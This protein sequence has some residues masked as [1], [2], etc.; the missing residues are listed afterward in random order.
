MMKRYMIL[1]RPFVA[2]AAF[3]VLG[4]T[5]L[6]PGTTVRADS[7]EPDADRSEQVAPDDDTG[8]FW[9]TRALT[10]SMVRRWSLDI[11]ET[12][13]LSREQYEQLESRML[14]RWPAFFEENRAELQPLVNEYLELRM[15]VEPPTA[16]QVSSWAARAIPALDR[17]RGEIESAQQDTLE[18]LDA[19]QKRKFES[20]R[21]KLG[22]AL[23]MAEGVLKQWS[24]GSF[25]MKDVWD[26]PNGPTQ[27]VQGAPDQ[28]GSSAAARPE[29][30]VESIDSS[31][32]ARLAEELHE[33]ERYVAEFCDRYEL[34]RSQRNAADSI[35]REMLA[36]AEDYVRLNRQRILALERIF[37]DPAGH[38]EASFDKE[39][40][41]VY[42]PVDEMFREL[43]ER[44]HRLPTEGQYRKVQVE[45]GVDGA[46]WDQHRRTSVPSRKMPGSSVE[47]SP[48]PATQPNNP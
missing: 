40:N 10:R 37:E 1:R 47:I 48:V 21:V 45:E 16:D 9:P 42:G 36:R 38:D 25:R 8:G 11:A 24:V 15:A 3:A 12:Y 6:W 29:R 7:P 31:C 19:E 33:W 20:E 28:D 27:Y 30:A 4:V 35:L 41:E 32:P 44:V 14:E 22:G 2:M 26:E 18:V 46:G 17:I 43:D 13:N 5:W 34:D 39:I 23:A